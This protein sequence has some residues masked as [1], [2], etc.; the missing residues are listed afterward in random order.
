MG[1]VVVSL[2][3]GCWCDSKLSCQRS[4]LVSRNQVYGV[5]RIVY[6]IRVRSDG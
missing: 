6:L 4:N 3:N 5:E 2:I 1:K